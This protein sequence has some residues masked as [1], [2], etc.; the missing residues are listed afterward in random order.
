MK[1]F[2]TF[3][4]RAAAREFIEGNNIH[5]QWRKFS[6]TEYRDEDES[7]KIIR[8]RNGYAIKRVSDWMDNPIMICAGA[9]YGA[10]AWY[11]DR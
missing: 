8:R 5:K 3:S 7:L 9:E 6:A 2:V 1:N 4:S 10:L 11:I